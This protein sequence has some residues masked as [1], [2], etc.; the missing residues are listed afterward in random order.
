[1]S[2]V[3]RLRLAAC[4]VLLLAGAI[5]QVAAHAGHDDPEPVVSAPGAPRATA[6]SDAFE[7]VAI[8]ADGT[9]KIYLDSFVTN[10]PVLGATIEIG[11]DGGDPVR[12]EAQEDGT[13]LLRAP[14]LGVAGAHDL[15]VAITAD[16]SSDLLTATLV[17]PPD[18]M[19][20]PAHLSK[21]ARIRGILGAFR[22]SFA[23]GPSE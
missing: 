16:G 8:A 19:V 10:A 13:Y 1:M 2:V 23:A 5:Q 3:R 21:A 9:L 18:T 22:T 6:A 7:F 11:S 14:W 20:A 4:A 12:A 17:L 15:V